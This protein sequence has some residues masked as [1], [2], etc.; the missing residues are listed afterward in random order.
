[1]PERIGVYVCH[2][3]SNIAGT[4]DVEAVTRWAGEALDGVVVSRD[5]KFLCSSL[6]QAM[7][8]EDIQQQGLTRVVVAACSPHLHERTFRRACASAGLNPFLL[9]MANVRE[10]V[11]WVT[12]DG[13]AATHKVKALLAGAVA[14]VRHHRPLEPMP[15]KV[16]PNTLVIGAGIAGIQAALELADAGYHV[17]LVER[18]PTIGGHMA[19]YDKTFPTLD[20]AACILT[21]KM[22]DVAQHEKIT[23][24]T[25]SEL[26]SVSGS[27]GNFK[28]NVRR[29]ARYVDEDK[30]TGCRRCV[31]RCPVQFKPVDAAFYPKVDLPP[32]MKTVVDRATNLHRHERGPLVSVLQDINI[33][34]RYLPPD[35]L[36]YVSQRL[37]IPLSLVYHVATFY[38]AFSL[39]PRGQHILKVC[40][41][42]ACHVRGS[43]RLLETLESRLEVRAGDTTKDMQFTLETVNC[44]GACA[45]GPLVV[46][47][48][49]Y[50][51][52][53]P[54]D[55]D[56]LVGNLSRQ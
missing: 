19:Q 50:V 54:K 51:T 3:G 41:G 44:L 29:K 17:Y 34:L 30:C 24:W 42:T 12:R 48:E 35:A 8:Q 33:D 7:I 40:V 9:Q 6:G 36:R 55:V 38:T 18:E 25:Y 16:N 21:P 52:A 39:T 53:R 28:V 22:S 37:Q 56:R 23:I 31:E 45:M 27:V 5:Y 15:V 20:C 26:E 14:R 1:M 4:V 10:H 49:E 13:Q 11:S 43:A 32:E 47:D 2:C 46:V